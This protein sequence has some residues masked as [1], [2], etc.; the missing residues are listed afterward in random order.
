MGS[1][2]K[3]NLCSIYRLIISMRSW[4]KGCNNPKPSRTLD[5]LRSHQG[6]EDA[7]G[8]PISCCPCPAQTPE[9]PPPQLEPP[10]L[11]LGRAAAEPQLMYVTHLLYLGVPGMACGYSP[12]ALQSHWA[13]LEQPLLGLGSVY[14]DFLGAA[15][16]RG[17]QLCAGRREKSHREV[18]QNPHG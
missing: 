17:F 2:C 4:E 10:A 12:R 6:G 5:R 9:H 3:L 14:R 1:V 18:T 7:P 11:L 8:A 13:G 15:P 16:A